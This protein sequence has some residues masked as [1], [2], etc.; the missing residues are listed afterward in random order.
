[1]D[2]N[3]RLAAHVEA[4][5]KTNG[6][7]VVLGAVARAAAQEFAGKKVCTVAG[8]PT[9]KFAAEVLGAIAAADAA[10]LNGNGSPFGRTAEGVR[11]WLETSTASVWLNFKG[12]QTA[13]GIASYHDTGVYLGAITDGGIFQHDG[14]TIEPTRRH[15]WT[16]AE[17]TEARRRAREAQ[18]AAREAVA[19]CGP[20]ADR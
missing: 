19:A 10:T 11:F 6:A 3:A 20:F 4:V 7:A 1:M 16:V 15:N 2:T 9:A 14:R 17:V 13:D 8:Q 5:N 18:E 12:C